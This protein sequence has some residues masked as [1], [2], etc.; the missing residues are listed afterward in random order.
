MATYQI[1]AVYPPR[2][3][4]KLLGSIDV[5][6][7]MEGSPLEVY[8]SY[9]KN[10]ERKQFTCGTIQECHRITLKGCGVGR[11]EKGAYVLMEPFNV[12]YGLRCEIADEAIDRFDLRRQQEEERA[13]S[14]GPTKAAPTA[15]APRMSATA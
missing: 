12:E 7:D 10:G 1:T 2:E 9:E 5:T 15:R 6:L 13:A 4:S 8:R 14:R 11:T 3:K